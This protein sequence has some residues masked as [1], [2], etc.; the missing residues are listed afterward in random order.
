[1]PQKE[2]LSKMLVLHFNEIQIMIV[3][4]FVCF[5]CQIFFEFVECG[6]ASVLYVK[7]FV[8]QFE[9]I[10]KLDDVEMKR[11]SSVLQPLRTDFRV[12]LIQQTSSVVQFV[13]NIAFVHSGFD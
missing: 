1:M 11:G 3:Q 6:S 8:D 13:H 9:R 7:Y 2:A 12:V 10:V 5:L 4:H